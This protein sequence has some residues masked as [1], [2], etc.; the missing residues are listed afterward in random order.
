MKL[1]AQFTTP[2]Y[3]GEHSAIRPNLECLG[4][5]MFRRIECVAV[6]PHAA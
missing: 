6:H 1:S 3:T 4:T 2:P 5:K